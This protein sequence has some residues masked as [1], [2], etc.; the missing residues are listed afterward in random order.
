MLITLVQSTVSFLQILHASH[1]SQ[2]SLLNCFLYSSRVVG[3]AFVDIFGKNIHLCQRRTSELN[4][5]QKIVVSERDLKAQGERINQ[6][7]VSTFHNCSL[8]W[9][10]GTQI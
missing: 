10:V 8:I 7:F 5:L 9:W 1:Y 4:G 6:I 3:D 2:H